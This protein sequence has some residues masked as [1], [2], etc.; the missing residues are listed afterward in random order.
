MCC[1]PFLASWECM[2]LYGVF[3][4]FGNRSRSSVA[5]RRVCLHLCLRGTGEVLF[6]QCL[7]GVGGKSICWMAAFR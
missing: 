5:K 2:G 6:V 3:S 4:F 7:W 1:Y